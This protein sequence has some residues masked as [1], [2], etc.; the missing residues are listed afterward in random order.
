MKTKK[1]VLPG[2]RRFWNRKPETRVVPNAKAYK[3]KGRRVTG[4][5]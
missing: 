4:S 1:K 2:L 3:R 5:S